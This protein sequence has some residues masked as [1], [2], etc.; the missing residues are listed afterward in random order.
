MSTDSFRLK[1]VTPEGLAL[2]EQV[3]SAT[4]PSAQGEIGILPQHI[5]YNGLLGVGL[6]TY[7]K[8]GAANLGKAVV[9]GGFCQ[10]GDGT[11]TVL[12]DS[13]DLAENIDPSKYGID[14]TELQKVI[15][16]EDTQSQK[17]QLA[18]DR[19]SRIEAIDRMVA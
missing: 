1:I 4:L 14:R 7:S 15:E 13:A 3:S 8:V 16:Q 11:L 17:W 10:F 6:L 2:D 12:A 18:K 5:D 19:L 9:C